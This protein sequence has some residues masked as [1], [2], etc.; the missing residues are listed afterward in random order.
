VA[1]AVAKRRGGSR[2]SAGLKRVIWV[3]T[4][5]VGRGPSAYR[6]YARLIDLLSRSSPIPAVDFINLPA[7]LSAVISSTPQCSG[8]QSSKPGRALFDQHWHEHS[9]LEAHVETGKKMDIF[10]RTVARHGI[11]SLIAGAE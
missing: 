2:L 1:A 7:Y 10:L 9:K 11:A 5:R 3:N 8:N 6:I 4:L